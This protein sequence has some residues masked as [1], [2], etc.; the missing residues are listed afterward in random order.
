MEIGKESHLDHGLSDSVIEDINVRFSDKAE[1]FIETFEVNE[2]VPCGLYGPVMGDAPIDDSDV[3]YEVRGDRKYASRLI[4]RPVRMQRKV[5][6]IAGPNGDSKCF[7]YTAF[8]GPLAPKEV[9]DPSHTPESL[10]ESKTFWSQHALS[11]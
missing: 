3:V 10:E 6:V 8:G 4:N 9:G 7:L 5:T 11:Y 2:D 1:F